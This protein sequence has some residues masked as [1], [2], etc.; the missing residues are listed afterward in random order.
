VPFD[1]FS[2]A[3]TNTYVFKATY[4]SSVSG[5]PCSDFEFHKVEFHIGE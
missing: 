2:S 1:S 4:D 5:G 3:T